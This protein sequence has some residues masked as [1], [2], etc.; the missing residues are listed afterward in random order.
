MVGGRIYGAVELALGSSSTY[1]IAELIKLFMV[2]LE[3]G[4]SYRSLLLVKVHV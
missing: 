1:L 4:I 2:E 3:F